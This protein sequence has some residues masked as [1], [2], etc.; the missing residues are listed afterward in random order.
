MPTSSPFHAARSEALTQA[1][2]VVHDLFVLGGGIV[3]AGVAR[4]AA[5]RGLKV[6]L[7]EKQDFSSGTSSRSSKLIHGGLRYL[8]QA[9]FS[10]VREAV[11]E[12]M[13]LYRV[14]PHLVRPLGFIFPVFR[15]NKPAWMIRVGLFIYDA[16]SGFATF[17]RHKA[18]L[19]SQVR[20]FAPG[21]KERG[22]RAAFFY[23]DAA[24]DD[25][26]LTLESIVDAQQLGASAFNYLS[27]DSAKR[28]DDGIWMLEVRD[29]INHELHHIRARSVAMCAGVWTDRVSANVFGLD[30]DLTRP[31]KGVHVLIPRERLPIKHTIAGMHPQD[32]RVMFVI[33]KGRAVVIGTTDTDYNDDLTEPTIER[34]DVD[35]LLAGAN[36]WFPDANLQR[37][38]IFSAYAGV[39]PLFNDNADADP[40]SVSRE[41]QVKQ[42]T[43]GLF[44]LI[45]GKLTTWRPIASDVLDVVGSYIRSNGGAT[46]DKTRPQYYKRPLPGGVDIDPD[47]NFARAAGPLAEQ[48]RVSAETATKLLHT[49]GHS[50]QQL[51]GDK[52]FLTPVDDGLPYV[53][54]QVD[55]AVEAESAW[56]LADVLIRRTDVIYQDTKM[57]KDIAEAVAERMGLLLGWDDQRVAAEVAAYNSACSV[58]L[59]A[60]IDLDATLS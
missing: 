45:G 8:E 50:A 59:A 22:R 53:L 46:M 38:D 29:I 3:G 24:T 9:E 1:R 34:N 6:F 5:F 13:S 58:R 43:D 16:M 18:L 47:M 32:K 55:H 49:Y 11:S 57:G 42:L 33:P 39:R 19:K 27:V 44:A 17:G 20:D 15:G 36:D 2:D 51:A 35:Y 26:R 41:H 31:A 52:G 54:E 10:L 4:E 12:R 7:A 25:A 14:A 48:W 21:L 56:T 40:S 60:L 30:T 37:R 23:Y 28:G